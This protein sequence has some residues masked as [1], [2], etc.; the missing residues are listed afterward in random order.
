MLAV[1]SVNVRDHFKEWRDTNKHGRNRCYI[2]TAK[3]K[4]I[5]DKRNGI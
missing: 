2:K 4:H 3:P 1:K 5:H